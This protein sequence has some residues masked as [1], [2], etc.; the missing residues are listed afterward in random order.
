MSA[1]VTKSRSNTKNNLVVH[2]NP[3][4]H[5]RNVAYLEARFLSDLM[6]LQAEG[7]IMSVIPVQMLKVT[8]KATSPVLQSAKAVSNKGVGGL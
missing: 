5:E 2:P 7:E 8:F 6:A 3:P 4:F 1:S